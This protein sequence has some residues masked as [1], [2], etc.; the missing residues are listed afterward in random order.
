MIFNFFQNVECDTE[1]ARYA[2]INNAV[3]IIADDTDFLIYEGNWKYWSARNLK[4]N[5]LSTME[6]SRSALR[7]TLGLAPKQLP[8]FATLA[9]NDII[10]Q[11]HIQPFHRRL[12]LTP[13]NRF[14]KL[15]QFVRSNPVD[16]KD[17]T[18][19]S[20]VIFGSTENHFVNLVQES[21]STYDI[22]Y[23]TTNEIDLLVEKSAYDTCFYTFLNGLPYNITL[24]FFDM[25][26]K[27]FLSYYDIVMPIVKRQIGFI[28]QHKNESDY[29]QVIITKIDHNQSYKEFRIT[30]EYPTIVLPNLLD[31]TFESKNEHLH[32]LRFNIL[33][34]LIF[35]C[36]QDKKIEDIAVNYMVV[37]STLKYLLSVSTFL[38]LKYFDSMA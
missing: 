30:P 31:I 34:W 33:T 20:Y 28:R 19:L 25:R 35:G 5:E 18:S 32:S 8:T 24:M 36:A 2:T 37:V 7:A 1:L 4:F 14:H 23:E 29:K 10:R 21:I 13:R 11:E 27:D 3:A 38:I 12:R 9:G 17:A 16:I 6:Y 22:N 15:A 26:R